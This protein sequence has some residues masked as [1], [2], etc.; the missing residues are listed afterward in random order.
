SDAAHRVAEGGLEFIQ[1]YR[2]AGLAGALKRLK[3]A[4]RVVAAAL[5]RGRPLEQI[6]RDKPIALVLGNEEAGLD[7]AT[8]AACDEI[9]TLP[10]SGWV[11]SLNVSAASAVLIHGLGRFK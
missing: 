5:E 4:Y 11:Q 3:P 6:A 2:A 1:V 8:I 7:A 9:V 10:G